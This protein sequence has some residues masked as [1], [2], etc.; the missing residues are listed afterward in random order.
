MI[1]HLLR[2]PC[3]TSGL[4]RSMCAGV[5]EGHRRAVAKLLQ[6]VATKKRHT[7]NTGLKHG[8]KP[9]TNRTPYC[10]LM[11]TQSRR[12]LWPQTNCNHDI[13]WKT[14]NV[15]VPSDR[16]RTGS[17]HRKE[18]ILSEDNCHGWGVRH[19]NNKISEPSAHTELV[20]QTRS[21]T[22]LPSP[23]SWISRVNRRRQSQGYHFWLGL[24]WWAQD[25]W[26]TTVQNPLQSSPRNPTLPA[27]SCALM[28]LLGW[29][30]TVLVWQWARKG[31]YSGEN[32]IMSSLFGSCCTSWLE[33]LEFWH[34]GNCIAWIF[35]FASCPHA[36]GW[37]GF[38]RVLLCEGRSSLPMISY[39]C[40]RFGVIKSGCVIQSCHH[41]KEQDAQGPPVNSLQWEL[42]Q[43]HK[44]TC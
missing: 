23:H 29:L 15:E 18:G 17:L 4:K 31:L 27:G 1:S 6:T 32:A 25:D 8:A 39:L 22:G 37:P 16:C 14:L 36:L 40:S 12:L 3:D 42:I 19:Y 30:G 35:R 11:S 41:F 10:R 33:K 44:N 9:L 24:L 28:Q 13:T 7:T 34:C 20:H 26:G 21:S 43:K 38:E 2:L 5:C